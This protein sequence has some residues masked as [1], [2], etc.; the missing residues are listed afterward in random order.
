MSSRLGL[1]KARGFTLIELMIVVV[2]VAIL[3]SIAYPSYTSQVRKA[4]RAEAKAL[5]LEAQARQERFF[6]T[7]NSYAVDMTDLGYGADNQPTEG[8]WYLV[9][10]AATPAGCD[11]DPVT[12]APACTGFTLTATAQNGQ[13]DD[14]CGNLTI[15]SVGVKGKSGTGDCW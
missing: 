8:N 1:R 2:V 9:G 13:E 14:S 3:A 12:P 6:S 11:S 4:R 7:N 15:D 10:S 5:L